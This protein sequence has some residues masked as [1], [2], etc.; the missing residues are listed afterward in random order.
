MN[1]LKQFANEYLQYYEN[2]KKQFEMMINL[3]QTIFS[4]AG[5]TSVLQFGEYNS[6][7]GSQIL[8]IR[9]KPTYPF[10]KKDSAYD[11]REAYNYEHSYECDFTITLNGDP[12]NLC[13]DI[14]FRAIDNDCV[15]ISS[16]NDISVK[17]NIQ[18]KAIIPSWFR[19]KLL[20][21]CCKS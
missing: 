2:Q 9:F 19:E 16:I 1:N 3:T 13:F 11:A 8:T 18:K 15:L 6:V 17:N 12:N 5:I 7:K 21:F 10:S 14:G 4:Q 20:K